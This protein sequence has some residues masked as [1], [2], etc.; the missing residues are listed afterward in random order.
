[1]CRGILSNEQEELDGVEVWGM[2][3]RGYTKRLN[4]IGH[5]RK[6]HKQSYYGGSFLTYSHSHMKNAWVGLS[7]V[8]DNDYLRHNTQ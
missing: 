1:M 8:R 6:S 2:G 3:R 4:N 5:L 7:Y